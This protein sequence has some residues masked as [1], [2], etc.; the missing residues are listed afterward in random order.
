MLDGFRLTHKTTMGSDFGSKSLSQSV[1][2]TI[3]LTLAVPIPRNSQLKTVRK[4]PQ[5]GS[6]IDPLVTACEPSFLRRGQLSAQID[7]PSKRV[8]YPSG[9]HRLLVAAI[10]S[11]RNPHQGFKSNLPATTPQVTNS[12]TKLYRM[13]LRGVEADWCA[14]GP[15]QGLLLC[16][17]QEAAHS[18]RGPR[19]VC[20]TPTHGDLLTHLFC[21]ARSN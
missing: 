4:C 2:L 5:P 17:G 13:R 19:L 10:I 12:Q 1:V 20:I 15:D 6:T 16:L 9:S 11:T 18:V 7:F 3:V 8:F 14:C 21:F